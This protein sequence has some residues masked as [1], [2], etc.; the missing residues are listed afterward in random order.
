MQSIMGLAAKGDDEGTVHTLCK[1]VTS[2]AKNVAA[3][4]FAWCAYFAS[5]WGLVKHFGAG[6]GAAMMHQ[7]LVALWVT[8]V[9]LIMIMLLVFIEQKLLAEI[10]VLLRN[11]FFD[12]TDGGTLDAI[13]AGVLKVAQAISPGGQAANV[14]KL[15]R[16]MRKNANSTIKAIINA[17]GI[18][19]GFAW[20]RAFDVAVLQIAASVKTVI[21]PVWT[22]LLLGIALSFL[23]VPSQYRQIL[24]K[25]LDIKEEE[26]K[27]KKDN[28][29]RRA[30]ARSLAVGN[31]D[32][33][34]SSD[35]D[36]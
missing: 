6:S 35:S 10:D 21:E 7:L 31:E 19:I 23:V 12:D 2:Q 18:L 15:Q 8:S 26:E 4:T 28:R 9:A 32:L 24:R 34:T 14:R 1:R 27:E 20:E 16:K 5:E 25:I 33:L 22:K 30:E 36:E 29:Q 3:M 13:D 17:S 11:A